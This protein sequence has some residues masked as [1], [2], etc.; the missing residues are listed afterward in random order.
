MPAIVCLGSTSAAVSAQRLEKHKSLEQ[1]DAPD[2]IRLQAKLQNIFST[3][4]KSNTKRPFSFV[5]LFAEVEMS[6]IHAGKKKRKKGKRRTCYFPL[7]LFWRE[8]KP[9]RRISMCK[10]GNPRGAGPAILNCPGDS[11]GICLHF[12]RNLAPNWTRCPPVALFG[13]SLARSRDCRFRRNRLRAISSLLL[14]LHSSSS[15]S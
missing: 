6:A 7:P 10:Q 1:P 12:P 15:L 14:F 4:P 11:C 5:A 13:D 2:C 3:F 9:I 8:G